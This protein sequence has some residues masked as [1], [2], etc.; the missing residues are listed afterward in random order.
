MTSAGEHFEI[1]RSTSCST[2]WHPY[3]IAV[4]DPRELRPPTDLGYHQTHTKP[5]YHP[6]STST[7]P[8]ALTIKQVDGK[9]GQVYYPLQLTTIPSQTPA[10][11]QVTVRISAAA[12]NHRDLFIRQSLYPAVSFTTP[13]LA[14]GV[15]VVTSTGSDPAAQALS[16]KRVILNPGSGWKDSPTGPEEAGGYKILGGTKVNPLGTA[17][18]EVVADA[19]ELELAPE[20]LSD[21]EAAALPLAGLTAW[22]ATM[23][24]AEVSRGKNVL[25]TGIGGGVAIMALLYAVQAGANVWVSSGSQDKLDKARKMGAAG[26]INYK[27]KE[28]PKTLKGMLPKE[29]PYLDAIVDGAGGEV[30]AAGTRLLKDGGII[31]QYGMTTSPKMTWSM[32]A[33]LKNVE[34]RG[35]TMGSRKEFGEMVRFVDEKGLRPIVSKVASGGLQDLKGID[36]LYEDMKSGSQFGKLVIDLSGSGSSSKL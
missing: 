29:R 19:A 22:R 21:A 7:M 9:P 30:V 18:E 5:Q 1:R 2:A 15:G 27:D 34:L 20:H 14:D 8:T 16:G 23:V 4:F 24:K 11:N 25:V 33:V 10:S 36:A 31:S 35:S 17:C 32:P 12:L 3:N 13:Q 28:W 26:G 6:T